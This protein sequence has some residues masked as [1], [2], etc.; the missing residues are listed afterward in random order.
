MRLCLAAAPGGAAAAA[1]QQFYQGR[2]AVFYA[3][4]GGHAEA[5]GVLLDAGSDTAHP[6]R[7][8][9]VAL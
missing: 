6:D 5:M 4:L 7:E 2:T 9:P 3:A 1:K 8:G